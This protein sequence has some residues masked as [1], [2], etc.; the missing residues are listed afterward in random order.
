MLT[1]GSD[2][3]AVSRLWLFI[4][5]GDNSAVYPVALNSA[6]NRMMLSLQVC[7]CVIY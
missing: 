7:V 3:A 1:G 5:I 6:W 4:K 2:W